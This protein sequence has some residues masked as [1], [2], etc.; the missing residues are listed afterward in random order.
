MK[1][2]IASTTS[3]AGVGDWLGVCVC[4]CVCVCLKTF[5]EKKNVHV[6]VCGCGRVPAR[7]NSFECIMRACVYVCVRGGGINVFVLLYSGVC[8]CDGP[9]ICV[10]T[11]YY[12]FIVCGACI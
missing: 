3:N 8:V 10:Y 1:Q 6:C 12:M 2:I 5:D 9:H 4:V 11:C 7:V